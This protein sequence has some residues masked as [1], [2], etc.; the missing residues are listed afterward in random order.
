MADANEM[1]TQSILDMTRELSKKIDKI[2]D[3]EI[4]TIEKIINI[5]QDNKNIKIRLDSIEDEPNKRTDNFAKWIGIIGG[6]LGIIS[7]GYMIIKLFTK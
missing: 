1:L 6:S 3:K 2:V 7:T 4:A 5:E